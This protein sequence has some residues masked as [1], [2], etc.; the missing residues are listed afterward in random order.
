MSHSGVQKLSQ[1]EDFFGEVAAND[2]IMFKVSPIERKSTFITFS[3]CLGFAK[4]SAITDPEDLTSK[5]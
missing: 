5:I 2:F 4:F 3:Q 1:G